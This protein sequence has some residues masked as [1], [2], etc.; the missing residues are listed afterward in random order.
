MVAIIGMAVLS[1]DGVTLYLPKVEAQRCADAGELAEHASFLYLASA[2]ILRTCL[3]TGASF[4][5]VPAE[6]PRLRPKLLPAQN[7][8]R[9]P[10]IARLEPT[11]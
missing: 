2:A 10:D 9:N 6:L 11:G 4:V 8:V 3:V 7:V 5:A 1:I